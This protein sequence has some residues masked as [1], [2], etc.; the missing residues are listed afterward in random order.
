MSKVTSKFLSDTR[1]PLDHFLSGALV[2]G[3]GATVYELSTTKT[4]SK[5]HIATNIAKMSLTGGIATAVAISASNS[6][7]R[8]EY[9]YAATKIVLGIGMLITTEKLINLESK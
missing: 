6:I 7:A 2:A 9:A 3:M 1:L 8:R 4:K 5:K